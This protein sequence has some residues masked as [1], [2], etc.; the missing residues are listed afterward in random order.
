MFTAL[1]LIEQEIYMQVRTYKESRCLAN[2]LTI[3]KR[4]T[5]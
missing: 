5:S 3:W 1:L 2:I 4:I